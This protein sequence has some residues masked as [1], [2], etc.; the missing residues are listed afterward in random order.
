MRVLVTGAAGFIGSHVCERLLQDGHAVLA[1]DRPRQEMVASRFRHGLLTLREA[2]ARLGGTLQMLEVDLASAS[3]LRLLG[4]AGGWDAVIHL[5]AR[6]G[7]RESLHDPAGT[8]LTNILGTQWL[9]QACREIA[10]EAPFLFASSSSVYGGLT[11]CQ[12]ASEWMHTEAPLSPY[13]M[14][15]IAGELAVRQHQALHGGSAALLRFF[16]VYGPRQ[17]PDLVIARFT[18]RLLAREAITVY[19]NGMSKRDY[20]YVDDIVEGLMLNLAYLAGRGRGQCVTFNLGH[21]TPVSL[22][23]MVKLLIAELFPH[24]DQAYVQ[25]QLRR[26]GLIQFGPSSPVDPEVTHAAITLAE[27]TLGYAPKVA[28][29]E[30]LRRYVRWRLAYERTGEW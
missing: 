7:V 30:G 15:K 21:G 9:L 14:T 5:A 22:M 27:K 16:S 2:R 18:E 12:G 26:Q 11:S 4:E 1:L 24:D 19:G 20:T 17:R 23:S 10:P 3:C 28:I 13:A 8:S 6:A 29:A 25:E